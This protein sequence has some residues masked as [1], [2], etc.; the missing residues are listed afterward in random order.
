MK[1]KFVEAENIAFEEVAENLVSM[2]LNDEKFVFDMDTLY[3]LAF[4]SAAFLAFLEGKEEEQMAAIEAGEAQ[5][6]CQKEN[7][8]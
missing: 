5:C 7:V 3:D 2:K 8:H 1:T 4:R 6:L